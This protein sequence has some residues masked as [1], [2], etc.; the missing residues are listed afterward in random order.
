M[1][2]SRKR[3]VDLGTFEPPPEL[4]LPSVDRIIEEG[5][6]I[7][8]S[9][10][11]M[12]LKNRLITAA[13]R[14]SRDYDAEAL[15]ESARVEFELLA[16]E[17]DDTA[18]RLE[19][20]RE[21]HGEEPKPTSGVQAAQWEAHRRR[22]QVH[23]LLAVELR[24]ESENR[25]TID[26]LVERARTDAWDEIG[27]EITVRLGENGFDSALDPEYERERRARMSMFVAFDLASLQPDQPGRTSGSSEPW[28]PNQSRRASDP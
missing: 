11:R 17:N 8:V 18:D 3:R 5:V 16:R 2:L 14:D 7:S 20:L 24:H 9:S 27:R 26:E 15:R 13:L 21:I 4:P 6:L 23:R 22:P 25:D 12:A 1:R 19:Q 28:R 10:V